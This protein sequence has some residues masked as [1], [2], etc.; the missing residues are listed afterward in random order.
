MTNIKEKKETSHK[1]VIIEPTKLHI[2]A[3]SAV[4]AAKIFACFCGGFVF[5]NPFVLGFLAPFACSLTAALEG[6]YAYAACLGSCIGAMIFFDGTAAAKYVAISPIC[7]LLITL[8][9]RYLHSKLRSA[10]KYAAVCLSPLVVGITVNLATGFLTEELL[11]SVC[12]AILSCAGT[13]VFSQCLKIFRSQKLPLRLTY[14]E[15]ICVICSISALL[16]CFY[17]FTVFRFSPAAVFLCAVILLSARFSE[18][19]DCLLSGVCVGIASGL[20]GHFSFICIAYAAAGLAAEFLSRK[21]KLYAATG[22]LA[23][24][25]VGSLIDGSLDAY[26]VVPAALIASLAFVF[27]PDKVFLNLKKKIYVPLPVVSE[28]TDRKQ[29]SQKLTDASEA[30]EKVCECVGTVRRTLDK[31]TDSEQIHAEFLNG[32]EKICSQCDMKASCRSEIKNVSPSAIDRLAYALQTRGNLDESDF[33]KDFPSACYCFDSMK[34]ELENRCCAYLAELSAK[35]KMEQLHSLMSDQFRCVS[36]IL[37]GIADNFNAKGEFNSE[38]AARCSRSASEFGLSVTE[39]R[40]YMDSSEKCCLKLTI[41]PPKDNFNV[42]ALTNL[43]SQ[44]ANTSFD[45]PELEKGENI[46]VLKFT[47]KSALSVDIGAYSRS[48]DDRQICGDYYQSFSTENGKYIAILSD[49]MGT[50][51]RA[52]VDSAMAT[53]LFSKLIQSGLSFNCALSVTNSALLVKSEEESLATLDALQIDLCNG[54]SE[55]YKAGA[56]AS[57]L[58]RED[59]ITVIES[60]SLPIGILRDVGFAETPITLKRGDWILMVSDGVVSDGYHK[61]QQDMKLYASSSPAEF[62][63]IIVNNACLRRP[64]KQRDDMT[65]IAIRIP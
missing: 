62:A 7:L 59:K 56:A 15:K 39:A 63:E 9:H 47:P 5:S 43:L 57:F 41:L 14:T 11:M 34:Q 42:T 30:I 61:I 64:A 36:D 58:L 22:F 21:G 2:P 4:S 35:G 27:L 65:A 54:K 38:L 60:S 17:N 26:M 55:F 29:I 18:H 16:M 52:A 44:T 1:N 12:E 28:G 20:S 46:C 8:G 33:P 3:I 40:V 53:E 50:G 37:N 19:F 31:A 24:I 6:L 23:V 10:V 49:G 32:W 48:A 45:L 25:A 13:F 51:S